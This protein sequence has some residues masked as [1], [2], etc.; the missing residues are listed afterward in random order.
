MINQEI[1]QHKQTFDQAIHQLDDSGIEYCLAR[2]LM[3][4]LEYDR[5]ENFRNTLDEAKT[6]CEN[7]KVPVSDHFRDT[8]KMV[9]LRSGVDRQTMYFWGMGYGS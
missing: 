5:W 6:A 2:E 8:T 1:Q 7:S 3:T 9:K 4:L